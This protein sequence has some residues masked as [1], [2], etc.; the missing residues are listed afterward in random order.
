MLPE[1]DE[2]KRRRK[3]MN[4]TQSELANITKV[5]Q[6]LIAKVESGKIIP[7][8]DKAKR[9]FDSLEKLGMES[10]L[11]VSDIMIN[12]IESVKGNDSIKKAIS[13]MERKGISQIPVI[14]H[15][16]CIGTVSEKTIL[17][18][19]N[20]IGSKNLSDIKVSEVMDESLPV[21]QAST[22][23]E[24]VSDLLNYNAALLVSKKGKLTGIV[25]K[26]DLLK[27]MLRKKALRVYEY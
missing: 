2:I 14:E 3:Q 9:I 4:L 16:H 23:V 1:I 13:L 10:A 11:K 24:I 26:A 22:P 12:R 6:S 7:T 20:E 21:I 18:K 27:V 15:G 25:T 19:V 17:S 5:S 8:Y